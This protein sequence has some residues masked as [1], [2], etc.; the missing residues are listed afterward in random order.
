MKKIILTILSLLPLAVMAQDKFEIS[1]NLPKA[2]SD[3]IAVLSY[4]NSQGKDKNDTAAVKNGKF[5][6]SGETAFGN[7]SYLVLLP[8][9][10]DTAKR[11]RQADFQVFY[12]EK[13]KYNVTGTDSMATAKIT[14]AQAQTDF[15]LFNS[16][17]DTLT[18]H[19]KVL[20]NRFLKARSAKDTAEMKRIQREGKPL[21]VRMNAAIDAFIFS[22]PDSYVTLDLVATEKAAVI[23]PKV[24]DPY[25]KSL[26]KRV[27]SSFTGQK[28]AA[29]YAKAM[30]LSIG[31]TLDFTQ[32]DDKG[33]EFKLSSLKGKY[34]L[35]DFWASW[36]APCRAE[37]PNLLK[38]YKTLKDKKFEIVGISLDETK[39]AWLKAVAA[40]AMPWIQVS[41]LKGFK[42][43]VAVRFGISAIPQNVLINPDGMI[44]AKNLRGEDVLSKLSE[45]IK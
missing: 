38:A 21:G 41:D 28:L 43:D 6:I 4:K 33:N 42:N 9:K 36:C 40:D 12:L 13:G 45:F 7:R 20:T 30:Q 14:G 22:H 39:A 27:M 3:K 1:G 17:M 16:K 32:T 11:N 24:F 18:A 5:T 23:D 34:V 31:K 19:Y 15:L 26:S 29:R 25:Y 2:G 10:K 35:V 44:I 8:V 37:N